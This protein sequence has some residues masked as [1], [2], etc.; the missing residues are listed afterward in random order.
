[1]N[2]L[3]Y[4]VAVLALI[5]V[6]FTGCQ[7]SPLSPSSQPIIGQW[8]A[9]KV[10]NAFIGSLDVEFKSDGT[11]T[12]QTAGSTLAGTFTTSGDATSSTV[13]NITMNVTS[14]A[15]AFVGIY[16]ITGNEMKLEV[17]HNP[18]PANITSP[19][20]TGGIGSTTVDGKKTVDYVSVLTK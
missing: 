4:V 16:E 20:P 18:P 14:P 17:V 12:M 5:A 15:S 13:R 7:D 9:S 2:R 1:M 19:D 6:V 8:S 10:G 11:F 3:S